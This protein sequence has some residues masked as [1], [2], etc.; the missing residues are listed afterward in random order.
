MRET[1]NIFG[2]KHIYEFK[3]EIKSDIDVINV[4]LKK[5]KEPQILSYCV[6]D[7]INFYIPG[8]DQFISSDCVKWIYEMM[9]GKLNAGDIRAGLLECCSEDTEWTK[10]RNQGLTEI[11]YR[12]ITFL[13]EIQEMIS[14]QLNE[15]LK[16]LN[17]IYEDAIKKEEEIRIEIEKRKA[18]WVIGKIYKKVMPYGGEEGRDG[19]IDAEYT[20]QNT[21]ET[22]RMV[23]RDVFDVGCYSYPKRLEG[24][25]NVFDRSL[26]TESEKNLA[27][28]LHEF[29]EFRGMR[30]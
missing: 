8:D 9:E 22:I 16:E 19:Y 7:I 13:P 27:K 23:R 2:R 12:K 17:Q 21:E 26:W 18:S 6:C 29:G 30:M 4:L 15:Y 14:N 24:T 3:S 10:W 5:I 28:W 11:I 1:L 25:E 20:S